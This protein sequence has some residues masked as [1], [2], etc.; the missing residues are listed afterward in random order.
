MT[1]EPILSNKKYLRWDEVLKILD[2]YGMAISRSTL[3]N[4]S[5]MGTVISVKI[6]GKLWFTL[7]SIQN[8]IDPSAK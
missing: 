6:N 4:W 5:A 2:A 7:E 3:Y 1:E 8:I